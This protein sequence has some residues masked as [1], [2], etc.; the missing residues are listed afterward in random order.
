MC[1]A[2]HFPSVLSNITQM[3]NYNNKYA[4]KPHPKT[5]RIAV[6]VTQDQ[7]RTWQG[8]A[9]L[10][11]MTLSKWMAERVE[12]SISQVPTPADPVQIM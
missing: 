12:Q 8:A 1:S 3:G 2:L 4:K 11:G 10:E 6:R 7:K 9:N 5:E